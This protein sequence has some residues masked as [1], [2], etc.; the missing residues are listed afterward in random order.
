VPVSHLLQSV[1][2]V[3][4]DLENCLNVRV[5]ASPLAAVR[6]CEEPRNRASGCGQRCT[7][8]AGCR[9]RPA[10]SKRHVSLRN[11]LSTSSRDLGRFQRGTIF[12]TN[13]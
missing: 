12:A 6:E 8:K 13:W 10:A 5:V 1:R 9:I 2:I 3:D 7:G 11:L 4:R